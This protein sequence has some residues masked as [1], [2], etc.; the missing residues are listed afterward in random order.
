MRICWEWCTLKH[1]H[2]YGEGTVQVQKLHMSPEQK[3]IFY[4]QTGKR[5]E[6]REEC[7]KVFKK[8]GLRPAEK[9]EDCAERLDALKEHAVT[10]RPLEEKHTLAGMDLWGEFDR[11]KR[12]PFDM[13]AR[14]HY[15]RQRLERQRQ[16][17][18]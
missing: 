13:E 6:T 5:V 18:E 2:T 7:E 14:Y 16:E 10:G 1:E 4:L 12:Q 3:R 11:R 9:G 8:T 15:H 17:Q